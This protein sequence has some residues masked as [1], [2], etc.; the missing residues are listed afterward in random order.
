MPAAA[1]KT[2]SMTLGYIALA[3]AFVAL[4][5]Q[6]WRMGRLNAK[7]GKASLWVH[8]IAGYGAAVLFSLLFLGMASKILKFG[9]NL[10]ARTAWHAAAGLALIALLFAKWAVV[11]PYRNLMK[12]A[13][14]LGITVFALAFVVINLTSTVY[15]LGRAGAPKGAVP[16]GKAAP[17][18]AEV[19][20]DRILVADKC[21][22]CHQLSLVFTTKHTAGEWPETIRRMRGYD[23]KWISDADAAKIQTYLTTDYGPGVAPK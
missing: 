1:V 4:V 18:S 6:L 7:P 3:L 9:G 15:L 5:T 22:R 2:I 23:D 16:A 14:A 13:P 20:A 19:V 12:L 8:R 21:G 11:R 10:G 17:P